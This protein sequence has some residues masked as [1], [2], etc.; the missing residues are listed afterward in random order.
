MPKK[1]ERE[2]ERRKQLSREN[3]ESELMAAK[4]HLA[5]IKFWL[6]KKRKK[7]LSNN[8]ISNLYDFY[9]PIEEARS[10]EIIIRNKN[11]KW[12]GP[13]ME[14]PSWNN[15]A[16]KNICSY[17]KINKN[18]KEAAKRFAI[19]V[20]ESYNK[21][22]KLVTNVN[23]NFGNSSNIL[24]KDSYIKIDVNDINLSVTGQQLTTQ[25]RNSLRFVVSKD[26]K[27]FYFTRDHYDTFVSLTIQ[28]SNP[29]E[30]IFN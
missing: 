15:I 27:N 21:K 3:K 5:P 29:N 1:Q 16:I 17:L 6:S 11:D 26:G 8:D 22:K 28:S 14:T 23:E 18:S 19:G 12:K 20:Y 4:G 7:Y 10:T 24:P 9:F 2:I 25:E 13:I 30:I